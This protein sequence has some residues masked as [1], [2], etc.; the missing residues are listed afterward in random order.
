[1]A[2]LEEI[3]KRLDAATKGKWVFDSKRDTHDCCIYVEGSVDRH[4]FIWV[5]EGGVVGSS[6]WIW[7]GD[8]DGEFIANSKQ[9]IEFLLAE[10]ERLKST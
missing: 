2:R 6:E 5:G 9:D 4:G 1:M 3:K 10:I 8:A 7:I